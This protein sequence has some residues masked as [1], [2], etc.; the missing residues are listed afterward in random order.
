MATLQ[1]NLGA[2]LKRHNFNVFRAKRNTHQSTMK[3]KF[4]SR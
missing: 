1:N 3:F 4:I 2:N